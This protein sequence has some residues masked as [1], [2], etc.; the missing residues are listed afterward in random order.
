MPYNNPL[1]YQEKERSIMQ[2]EDKR[3]VL[4]KQP[5]DV[6]VVGG[7]IAGVSAAVAA[8]RN[9][10]SVMLLEKSIVLGGLATAGLI[11]WYEPLCD[12]NGKQMVYGI[13]E[14][15]I[16]LSVQDAF[17][18][19]DPAWLDK[20]GATPQKRYAT[21]F[22]PT[23]FPM[24]LDEWLEKN[25]VHLMLDSHAVYPVMD[26][27]RCRGVMVE[28]KT[29]REF[30]P[31]G[32]VIDATGDAEIMDRAGMPTVNGKN[33]FSFVTHYTSRTLARQFAEDG[34]MAKFRK[35]MWAG[36]DLAGHGQPEGLERVAGTTAEDI[37]RFVLA[38]RKAALEKLRREPREDRDITMLPFMPQFRTIRRIQGK[39]LFQG[40]NGEKFADNIGDCGD[41]RKK[42]M[43]YQIPY[44]AL[45]HADFPNLWA[46]GR[47]ISAAEGDGWEVTR[48]IPVCALTGQAAGT[49]AALCVKTGADAD[50]LSID[51]LQN[52]LRH[53]G[54][55]ITE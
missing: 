12:G 46:A 14:E 2:F 51:L 54:V 42:G 8:A 28:S 3:P 34:N 25:N 13:G 35:W 21:H 55:N 19:L 15:L 52:T 26:G 36:S 39:T 29:G 31:A 11:S 10:A 16:R 9:G 22:S 6:V 40:I 43:H 18:D 24:V 48:V 44:G 32:A 1:Q 7:G 5:F 23:I 30:Y 38:G 49:A 37:T 4:E 50:G 53:A 33:W 47:I 45:Y 41:F 20:T 17:D 27:K